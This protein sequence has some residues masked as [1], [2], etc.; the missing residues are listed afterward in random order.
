MQDDQIDL[1]FK[2]LAHPE[3]RRILASLHQ[4]PGRSLFE[5][6]ASSVAE[7]GQP[8]SRQ[9]I[10]QHLDVL[11]RAGLLEITW[12]GRTKTHAI[13]LDPLRAAAKAAINRYL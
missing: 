9:T 1:V 12:K 13:N 7:N 2:A 3:R 4:R 8:L 10:S 5:I 6:C 11:E